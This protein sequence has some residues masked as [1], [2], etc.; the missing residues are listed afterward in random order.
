MKDKGQPRLSL[1]IATMNRGDV[2]GETLESIVSQAGDDVEIIVLDGASN[3]NTTQVVESF[4]QRLPAL[5]Y[6]RQTKN[7]GVDK[8]YDLAVQAATGEFCWLMSDDDL[9]EQGAVGAVLSALQPDC[10]LIIVNAQVRTRDMATVLEP[11]RLVFDSDREY[12]SDQWDT[13]FEDTAEYLSFIGCIVIRRSI[14]LERERDRYF[15]TLFIH[16]GV[17]FQSPLRGKVSVIAHPF[18]QIRYANALWKPKE[19][20]IWMFKW[21][22]LLWSF[23]SLSE[24][25]RAA[26]SPRDP[27]RKWTTLLFF[28][29]K[30]T[31][32]T[33]E[34]RSFLKPRLTTRR[35]RIR[36]RGAALVPGFIANLIALLYSLRPTQASR[37]IRIDVMKSRYFFGNWFNARNRT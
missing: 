13:F 33:S 7:G 8:D 30:G 23:D 22:N 19:F 36:A 9:L 17:I 21:P 16:M 31:Y 27:W 5:R 20:E 11:R 29:A 24:T 26:V 34:Y 2:I 15:G 18:I 3:D 35:E 6:I 14:W 4:Q 10:D 1:C 12:R 25:S 37:M 32:S 28:R